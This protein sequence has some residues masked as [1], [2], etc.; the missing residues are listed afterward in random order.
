M[1]RIHNRVIV[2]VGF[3]LAVAILIGISVE[4]H[5]STVRLIR[6]GD[7]VKRARYVIENLHNI[8]FELQDAEQQVRELI[9][10]DDMTHQKARLLAAAQVSGAFNRLRKSSTDWPGQGHDI[11]ALEILAGDRL[12]VL[13]EVV[14][15]RNT[16]NRATAIQFLDADQNRSLASQIDASLYAL[17]DTEQQAL[18]ARDEELKAKAHFSMALFVL[19]CFVS[20]GILSGVFFYLNVQI[21]ARRA[22]EVALAREKLLL[23][24]QHRRQTALAEIEF[25]INQPHELQPALDQILHA[26]TKLMPAGSASV[27]IWDASVTQSISMA[28]CLPVTLKEQ[29]TRWVVEH[30]Q[31]LIVPAIGEDQFGTSASELGAYVG[32]PLLLE[33]D[34]LGVL[35]ALDR[36]PRQYRDDEIDFL[37]SLSARAALAIS[38]VRLYDRLQDI[39]R[40]LEQRVRERTSELMATNE[41]LVREAEDRRRA[42]EALQILSGQLLQLQDQERRHIARE[43]HD[44]T[45]QNLS[46]ITLNLARVKTLLAGVDKRTVQVLNDSIQLAEECVR[47]I[48]TL[49]YVLH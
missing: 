46:A 28:G 2:A 10:T 47:G 12:R 41:H 21:A 3:W 16:Q 8:R 39:N 4:T 42:E 18:I 5:Q 17:M 30:K 24:Q 9:A 6:T 40:L 20:L 36:E 1:K 31:T 14:Q 15:L 22:A 11:A 7:R 35:Y 38:K 13:D 49:S 25:A 29:A 37:E 26:V 44:V 23:E 27:I 48:R 32:V 19:G 34:V 33:G 45:A 43:L